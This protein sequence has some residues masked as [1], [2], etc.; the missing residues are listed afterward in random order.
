[1]IKLPFSRRTTVLIL[2]LLLSVMVR[3]YYVNLWQRVPTSDPYHFAGWANGIASSSHLDFPGSDDSAYGQYPDGYPMYLHIISSTTGI[4]TITLT[5]WIPLIIGSLCVLPVYLVFGN[6]TKNHLAIAT[7][8]AIVVF[9]FAFLKYSTVS[10]P[11]MLGLYLFAFA[12]WLSIQAGIDRKRFV[13]ILILTTPV[14]VKIHYL[15]LVCVG[16]V[17]AIVLSRRMMIAA[18]GGL[19][20]IDMRKLAFLLLVAL[21]AGVVL[22][23]AAYR[24]MLGVYGIDITRQPPPRLSQSL[25][26]VGYPLVFGLLQTISLP[27]GFIAL[28]GFY[29]HGSFR[30]NGRKLTMD[31][32]L[33]FIVWLVFFVFAL[34]F[35][36]VEYYPFRFNCFLMLPFGMISLLGLLF[37]K[38]LLKS[39]SST[40][41]LGSLV[42]PTAIVLALLQPLVVSI[43][44]VGGEPFLPWKQEYGE[45]E[46]LAMSTWMQESLLSIRE[47]Q[48]KEFPRHQMIMADWVRSRALRAYGSEDVHLHWW[49]FQGWYDLEREPFA[50]RSL[51]AYG[52]DIDKALEILGRLNIRHAYGGTGKWVYYYKYIYTSGWLAEIMWDDFGVVADFEKFDI[53]NGSKAY[54]YYP[55]DFWGDEDEVVSRDE[56]KSLTT[57]WDYP[58]KPFD[59]L[60]ACD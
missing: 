54:R 3:L 60:Y 28:A 19:G 52:G 18:S 43:I 50:F 22:W 12:F 49:Y 14:L 4:D 51:D 37:V 30:R 21:V 56:P 10:I 20:T 11:N 26:F 45:A 8:C 25:R 15:S 58:V 13:A 17:V 2:L 34:G 29:Y 6:I 1:M 38:D 16:V 53:Y 46:N 35:L 55:T 48:L 24:I 23:T 31:P 9:S 5:E 36:Q 44:P 40:A 41:V 42:L 39:R 33:L 32:V 47:D 7:G 57:H 59:K 27:I